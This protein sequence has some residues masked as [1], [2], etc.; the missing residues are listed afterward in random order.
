M[1]TNA[2]A[3]IGAV[4]YVVWGL[5]HLVAARMVFALGQ[6]LEPGMVQGRVFQDAWNLFV[7][8]MFGI[9]VAILWNWKND[10]MGYWLNL[11]VVSA[12]DIGFIVF[13]LMPG[14]V[15]WVPGGLGPAVWIVAAVFST[16]GILQKG[17]HGS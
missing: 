14:L 15:P 2:Y 1:Q 7:F 5:L 9:A 16:L 3:K 11:A 13:L 8:A 6:T 17:K 10:R 4:A 12:A